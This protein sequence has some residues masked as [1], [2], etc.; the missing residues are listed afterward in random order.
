MGTIIERKSKDGKV[1]Y[2]AAIRISSKDVKYSES[3]TFS[4]RNL[5]ESWL[6]KREAEIELNPDSIHQAKTDDMRL[7]DAIGRYLNEL[8]S[9]FGRSHRASLLFI[10]KQSI[11]LKHIGKLKNMDFTN[12]ANHRLTTVKPQTLNGDMIAIRGV[13]R[14]AKLVWGMDVDLASFEDVMLGLRYARKIQSSNKRTRLPTNDELTSLT[15]YFY[16]KYHRHKSAYPMHLI[17]WLA[18]YTTRREGELT[19]MA[20]ADFDGEHW[21]I[22]DMKN[23]KGSSGNHKY[24]KIPT[25]ALP[26]IHALQESS[27]RQNMKLCTSYDDD[28]LLPLSSKNISK[29]FTDA[30]KILG[31]D[32]LHFHDLRHEGATRLAERGLTIPQMQ[33][34]TGHDSWS[35]LQRYTNLKKRDRMLEFAEIDKTLS[36]T[37]KI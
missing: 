28:L 27:I 2:R 33:E 16:Q 5:A 19:R 29:L 21:L 10:A 23:P 18:I 31:I 12:F 3:R 15:H 20:L 25:S 36:K 37:V 4:K 35:S 17:M 8:G 11:G 34:I 13:L 14:H 26:V 6:K 7:S 9:G 24:V 32:D 1:R 22:K 30:C